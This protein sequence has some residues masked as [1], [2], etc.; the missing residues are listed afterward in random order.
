M[1]ALD[2]RQR[3]IE[4]PLGRFERTRPRPQNSTQIMEMAVE[5]CLRRLGQFR[6]ARIRLDLRKRLAHASDVA[7]QQ[8]AEDQHVIAFDCGDVGRERSP[9]RLGFIEQHGALDAKHSQQRRDAPKP[10][11]A[12]DRTGVQVPQDGAIARVRRALGERFVLSKRSCRRVSIAQ[13]SIEF[14]RAQRIAALLTRLREVTDRTLAFGVA[15]VEYD[16]CDH[17]MQRERTFRQQGDETGRAQR[18]TLRLLD[19]AGS[20]AVDRGTHKERTAR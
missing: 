9:D 1:H 3:C 12:H 14:C 15:A 7:L 4:I 8:H 19:V 11:I 6:R 18:L 17:R 2:E 5:Q 16:G 13:R 20:H 10:R